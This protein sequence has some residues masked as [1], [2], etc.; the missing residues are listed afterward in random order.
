VG[1][2]ENPPSLFDGYRE[3]SNNLVCGDMNSFPGYGGFV[4]GEQNTVAVGFN[5]V[6]GGFGNVANGWWS[7]SVSG[8]TNNVASGA[9]SSVGGGSDVTESVDNGWAAGTYESH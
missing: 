4:A 5:S 2:D 7:S 3:G 8:G 9:C 6:S 1:W